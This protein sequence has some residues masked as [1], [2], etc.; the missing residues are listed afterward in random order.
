MFL[1]EAMIRVESG[2]GGDGCVSFVR[3][4]NLPRGGPDGGDGADGGSVIFVSSHRTVDLFELAKKKTFKAGKGMPGGVN[5][6][7]G[8]KGDDILIEVPVGTIIKDEKT[9]EILCDL[10]AEGDEFIACLGGKGGR[11]NFSYKSSINQTPREFQF[12]ENGEIKDLFL[13]LRLIADVGLVGFPNA[14]KSTFLSKISRATPK[15]ANFPFTTLN[16]NLGVVEIKGYGRA[17]IADLPGLIEGSSQGKGLGI[18]FLKHIQRT[19]VILHMID[20]LPDNGDTPWGNYRKIL[21]ELESYDE[22]LKSR[23]QMIFLT[24]SD[25][26]NALEIQKKFEIETGQ[27]TILISS[28]FEEGLEEAKVAIGK[29]LS[30]LEPK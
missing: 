18:K 13:E 12:G 25:V 21:K 22:S 5:V 7:N 29:L 23:H 1:D 9:G 16:P 15:I 26:D 28:L 24:K 2:K 14:G 4:K 30:T 19:R 6:A 27:E 10:K 3:K 11:G 8:Q 17:I 20:V